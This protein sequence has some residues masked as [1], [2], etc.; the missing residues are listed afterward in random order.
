MEQRP[1]CQSV[2]NSVSGAKQGS[3]RMAGENE[4]A[5]AADA[6]LCHAEAVWA[7]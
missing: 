6:A 4:A 2:S 7:E 1:R 3:L 5:G